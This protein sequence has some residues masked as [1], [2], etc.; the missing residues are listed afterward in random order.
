VQNF[1]VDSKKMNN[2]SRSLMVLQ[3]IITC[4]WY[5]RR[6]MDSLLSNH[7]R[8]I[9]TTVSC[10]DITTETM[11]T[12]IKSR[13]W[14][15]TI[16]VESKDNIKILK[17]E[18][19]L[20]HTLLYKNHNRFR[21]DKGYKTLRMIEKS[22]QKFL[23]A[24][25]HSVLS[26]LLQFIPD[27]PLQTNV[28]LPTLT[29]CQHC[30]LQ[31]LQSTALLSKLETLCRRSGLLSM[32]RLNLG[33]FWGVA[34]IN[35]AV[36][37][38]IWV[39]ACNLLTRHQIMFSHL[40]K[41]SSNLP[42]LAAEYSLPQDLFEFLPED[43]K[44]QLQK[45]Q[46]TLDQEANVESKVISVDDFLDIGEPVKRKFEVIS[47]KED[48]DVKMLRLSNESD[49]AKLEGKDELSQIHSLDEIKEFMK[50]ETENRRVSKKT[51]F[52]R[53]LNQDQWKAVKKEVLGNMNP[54]LPNKSI[55]LC[56][57]IIRLALN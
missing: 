34:A 5:F 30:M 24:P 43:L 7:P 49:N 45:E 14:I 28:H 4:Y 25:F 6:R 31:C 38:R 8:P 18:F 29:M 56:R 1:S 26:D 40:L 35:L 48:S 46:K 27:S 20:L 55:K 36:V 39:I 19:N 57:K 15:R 3:K 10:P 32:Q 23:G 51:S 11:R 54:K 9:N 21:N 17:D 2:C 50:K 52:T 53:K 37:G 16:E 12:I 33:H 42:G 41:I 13:T 47:S 22:L 44:E